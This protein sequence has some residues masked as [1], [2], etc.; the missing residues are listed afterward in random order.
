V[1][2]S[3]EQRAFAESFRA[4]QLE[5]SVF[6]VCV[7]QLK[8]QLERLLELPEGALTKEIQLTQ[9]L[10]SLFVDYQIPSDLLSFDGAADADVPSKLNKVKEYVKTVLDVIESSK[11]K[12][13]IEEE[14]K[15]DMRGE[16]SYAT[17]EHAELLG[18]GSESSPGS[19]RTRGKV[20]PPPHQM[21]MAS[22]HRMM[23]AS[24]AFAAEGMGP[25]RDEPEK[26]LYVRA[27]GKKVRRVRK[28]P[29]STPAVRLEHKQVQTG[30][31]REF[32]GPSDVSLPVVAT[33]AEEDFTLIPKVL[34]Q[35]I[36]KY[37]TS[38]SLRSTIIK[39]GP[40]WT[41]MRQKNLLT[42]IQSSPLSPSDIETEKK[43]AFDLLDAISRSG[44]LPIA[45]AELHVVVAVS[46]C[47]DNDLM[48]TIIQDNINPIE[49]LERSSLMLAST[50]HGEPAQK[51]LED[52]HDLERLTGSFPLLFADES[53]SSE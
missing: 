10:M 33:L 39:T 22:P 17:G 4:M 1:S 23:V 3:P 9:D 2:L 21:M 48:G 19:G 8:P 13:L 41:R 50:I 11:E 7:I 52:E 31:V 46:H 51:L 6:G 5:S 45:C 12:Q 36:E 40:N 14:R 38:N 43:K 18:D 44:T 26:G 25:S 34:D 30:Q 53:E 15:A 16:L 24:P 28:A 47:F 42:S 27:D 37:D 35:Q 29:P 49:K 32:H 20:A